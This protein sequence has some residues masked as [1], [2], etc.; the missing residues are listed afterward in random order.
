[1]KGI[2]SKIYAWSLLVI[3]VAWLCVTVAFSV[4]DTD[5]LIE[6]VVGVAVS[7]IVTPIIH[8][9]GHAAFACANKMKIVYCKCFCFR[10]YVKNGKKRFGFANPLAADE[11]QVLPVGEE[12]MQKRAYRYAVGGLVCGGVWLFVLLAATVA[13]ICVQASSAYSVYALLPYAAYLFLINVVPTEYSSGRTDALVACGVKKGFAVEQTMLNLM[14]IH[15]GLAE[16][17]SFA[18]MDEKYYFSAPQLPM[19]EPLYVAILDVRYSYYLEKEN[20]ES[21]FDCLKRIKAAIEYLTDDEVLSLERNL[22]YLCL[23]GG[24]DEVLKEA[25]KNR[26]DFWASDDVAVKRTLALYMKECG[27]EERSALLIEQAKKLLEGATPQGL[28]KHE[29][30]LLSRIK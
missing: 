21:A 10:F 8:E 23:V 3:T 18:E 2:L 19:D 11:T 25:V 14:R 5:N 12:N 16:G 24:N 13:L 27:E 6:A 28:K 4:S 26:E 30:I 29:E 20:Y 22:A 9:L 7:L 15:G 17:K 1:M